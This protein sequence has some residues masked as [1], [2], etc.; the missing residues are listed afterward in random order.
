M[1]DFQQTRAELIRQLSNTPYRWQ[2][3][4]T[5]LR[6]EYEP[7][8]DGFAS[9]ANH[10]S[11]RRVYGLDVDLRPQHGWAV[12]QRYE[13]TTT[14]TSQTSAT[15]S[16][17]ALSR[18]FS[19]SPQPGNLVRA[20]DPQPVRAMVELVS[21]ILTQWGWRL[22]SAGAARPTPTRLILG[23]TLAALIFVILIAALI[24]FMLGMVPS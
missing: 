9:D 13:S 22:D 17:R 12:V 20:D 4:R 8:Q 3:T 6:V 7:I 14:Q 10:T 18:Q 15:G 19:F 24:F 2:E 1:A 21:A 16:S 23:L 5:G 11:S